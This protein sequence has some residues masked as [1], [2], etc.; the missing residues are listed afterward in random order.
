VSNAE[1]L[2]HVALVARFGPEWF[3]GAGR[4]DAPGTALVTLG[5]A[6]ARPGVYEIGLGTRLHDVLE[7]AGGPTRAVQ[8]VLVGGLFGRWVAPGDAAGLELV[9]DVLGA[10]AI[11]VLP[12]DV[13][14][15]AECA[16]VLSYLAD[17]SADQCGPCVHG[18]HAIAEVMNE[19]RTAA[20]GARLEEIA[21]QVIGRGAC[22]HPDG[23]VGF[24]SSALEVF[25][26]DFALH[27]RR[28]G[29]S[30]KDGRMLAVPTGVRR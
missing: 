18:L 17:E 7:R 27:A 12:A 8:G 21:A 3:R 28:G 2:A 9:P 25:A 30:R 22:R 15:V 14:A 10:G 23:A 16:R 13:C 19:S 6:V 1:T 29:C 20:R 4:P 11:V 5:G 24:L 26:D